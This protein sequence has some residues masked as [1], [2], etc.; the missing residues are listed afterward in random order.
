MQRPLADPPLE[1][2]VRPDAGA[3]ERAVLGQLIQP[4]PES[5]CG[6]PA[7]MTM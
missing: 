4:L 1:R 7:G 3:L 6:A 5:G 2:L